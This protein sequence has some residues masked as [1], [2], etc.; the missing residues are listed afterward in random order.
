MRP[1]P[2]PPRGWAFAGHRFRAETKKPPQERRRPVADIAGGWWPSKLA[3][4]GPVHKA[5]VIFPHA[6]RDS[7]LSIN[8][9]RRTERGGRDA[10]AGGPT[11]DGANAAIR[12]I[13]PGCCI[14]G[15]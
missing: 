8:R 12:A 5:T 15:T 10:L 13:F 3:N 14:R 6:Q 1:N 9:L 7:E 11:S 2:R 4:H